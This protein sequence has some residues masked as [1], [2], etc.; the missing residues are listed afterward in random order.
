VK[1][2][3]CGVG[4]IYDGRLSDT[5]KFRHVS[6]DSM[7]RR[8]AHKP[9]VEHNFGATIADKNI[10]IR[11]LVTFAEGYVGT[12][13]HHQMSGVRGRVIDW[14]LGKKLRGVWL[15]TDAGTEVY[16]QWRG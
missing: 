8:P 6:N 13:V 2:E 1:C 15:I 4:V 5:N 3:L 7:R 14:H 9:I 16:R 10:R 12:T 11:Q